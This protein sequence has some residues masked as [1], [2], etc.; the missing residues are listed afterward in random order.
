MILLIVFRDFFSSKSVY[1]ISVSD[2]GKSDNEEVLVPYTLALAWITYDEYRI[3]VKKLKPKRARGPDEIPPYVLKA[4][5]EVVWNH[6][7]QFIT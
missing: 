1:A 4:C 3:P 2:S 7:V 5:A 6:S